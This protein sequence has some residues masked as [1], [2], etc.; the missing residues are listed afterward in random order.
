V[1]IDDI[2]EMNCNYIM[3]S[4]GEE[5]GMNLIK[6]KPKEFV[7]Y[8]IRQNSRIYPAGGSRMN[9]SNYMP[10][11]YWNIGSQMV[12]LN[13]QTSDMPMQVN[14][15]K[16]EMNGGTGYILKPSV[17]SI[18]RGFNPFVQK[19][20]EDVVP[21]RLSVKII[22]GMFITS[23]RTDLMVE[24]E[25]YGLP[26]DIVRR[27]F[28]KKRS[29]APN[30][31][32]DEDYFVFKRVLMPELALLRLV[33]F[34][35]DHVFIGQRVLP[36]NHL[37]AGFRHV[38]LRDKHNSPLGIANLF[39]H[40][41]IE[42]YIPDEFEEFV[43]AL[44]NPLKFATLALEQLAMGTD[45]TGD[46]DEFA[47]AD[48]HPREREPSAPTIQTPKITLEATDN[49]TTTNRKVSAP[50][51][52][53]TKEISQIP[54]VASVP[55]SMD[56]LRKGSTMGIEKTF[57]L[58]EEAKSRDKVDAVPHDSS[59]VM[60]NPDYIKMQ[61]RFLKS[62]SDLAA[63]H[64]KAVKKLQ[65]DQGKAIAKLSKKKNAE[66]QVK[67]MEGAHRNELMELKK[68]N[69][70]EIKNMEKQYKIELHEKQK[71][72]L[73]IAHSTQRKLIEKAQKTDLDKVSKEI[74]QEVRRK[75][76]DEKNNQ[77]KDL[78]RLR[79]L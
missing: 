46:E 51:E 69:K 23:K 58:V 42:D 28:T 20:I 37:R 75:K 63:R 74:V 22:S 26:A 18:D 49:P 24:V 16:F 66:D 70:E 4:F 14:Y 56:T 36:V 34:D 13:F 77:N 6:S 12:A 79:G 60:E 57:P 50:P 29:P 5:K 35:S 44:E 17:L 53:L 15:A 73:G 21:A 47:E 78:M 71:F 62:N 45:A 8:N 52:L 27:Q 7:R 32:W 25:M 76:K 55:S 40:I 31:F 3:S 65:S 61:K 41:K 33:V 10:Q 11:I 2:L 48:R 9:S 72:L 30:P 64:D 38:S 68:H 39:L 54:S 59:I 67:E 1:N 43:T 19:K